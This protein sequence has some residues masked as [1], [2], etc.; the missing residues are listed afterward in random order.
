[1]QENQIPVVFCHRT[2]EGTSA[3]CVTWN[4]FEVGRKC[5][6]ALYAQGH[7]RV[8]F[9]YA[10]WS[11]LGVEY[12][13]GLRSAM[14]DNGKVV[15]IDYG[16]PVS[17]SQLR[18]PI[19]NALE[20][21]LAE[22]PRPTAVFCGNIGHAEQIYLQ[23]EEL[24]LEIPRDL[25]LVAFGGTWRGHGLAERISCVAVDEHEVGAKAVELLHEMR[26]GKRALD[27][28]ERIVFPVSMLPGETIS[29][30]ASN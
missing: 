15:S 21:L 14:G 19:R 26:S 10:R 27:N 18:E 17:G 22:S 29:Q 9:L 16:G 7:R 23:A 11:S 24:G 4:G 5:A 20:K 28:G 1:L 12:E 3:P 25:S 2:V 13:A 30:A 6:E 8:G